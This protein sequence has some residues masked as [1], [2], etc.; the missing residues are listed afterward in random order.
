MVAEV[1]A[2]TLVA[3]CVSESSQTT[4]NEVIGVCRKWLPA[5]MVPGDVVLLDDFPY[6]ASGKCDRKA[7]RA[8]YEQQQVPAPNDGS[9]Q[10]ESESMRQVLDCL[11]TTLGAQLTPKS[12]LAAAGLDSISSIRLASELRKR[13]LAQT[14]AGRVL[15]AETPADI[16]AII[17]GPGNDL[18]TADWQRRAKDA[19][20]ES[21]HQS[22]AQAFPPELRDQVEASFPCTP[23]QIAMLTETAKT[24]RVYCNWIKLAVPR[25]AD[26]E[27]IKDSLSELAARHP[28][29]RSGFI[30][31]LGLQQSYAVVVWKSLT[32]QQVVDVTEFSFP[33]ELKSERDF[34]RPLKFQVR[35]AE[36]GTELLVQIHHALYDQWSMDMLRADLASILQVNDRERPTSFEAVA[37]FYI[38][39]EQSDTQALADFWQD[40]LRDFAASP[41]PLLR[42][43]D[44]VPNLLRT[45][46]QTTSLQSADVKNLSK[47]IG[48]S[49]PAVFQTAMAII[50]G[51]YT[52]VSDVTFG[53]VFSGRTIPVDGIETIFGPCLATLPLRIDSK[54]AKT[55]RELLGAV[56]A[57][58]R[59]IQ[60]NLLTSPT[61]VR[62]AAGIAPGTKLFDSLFVWQESTLTSGTA[63]DVKE[64]DSADELEFDFVLEI[65]PSPTAIQ[66]RAT[67]QERL[68]DAQQVELFIRQIE[69]LVSIML[70]DPDQPV[71][72][73]GNKMNPELL[74][75]ANPEPKSYATLYELAAE[76]G[77]SASRD[78]DATAIIFATK[79]DEKSFE[80]TSIT[81]QD[82]DKRANR[83]A[84]ALIAAGLRPDDLVCICME[85]CID[86]Y[87][88]M[89]ATFKA[90]AG[91]LP[92]IP[93]T[94]EARI[95]SVL[96]Q[97]NIRLCVG[98]AS[99]APE[100]RSLT[101]AKVLDCSTLELANASDQSPQVDQNGARIAY[102][103]F[104]SGSTGEPKGV[105]VTM[106]NLK[107]N[108]AVLAEL[109]K[110]APG[111]RLLQA[112]SQ[113]FD[114]SVFEIFFTFYT[115]MCL[116]SATKDVIFRDFE[117]SIRAF[118][119]THLSLTPTVAALAKPENVPTV[120]FLVTAG[121]A[122]TEKVHRTWADHGLHQGYGPSETT[123]ICSV[124]MNV[125][126]H[127]VLGNIGPPFKNT[128][129]FVLAP[130]CDFQ[131][132]PAGAYGE[133]AFGGEQVFRGYIGRDDL[134][135]T[136]IIDHPSYGRVYRSGDMGR[137]LPDGT[138]L[139]AGRLDDQV[140][141]RGNR[142]ELGE[143]NNILSDHADVSD[144]AT[145]VIG[146]KSSDQM[147]VTFWVPKSSETETSSLSSVADS[148]IELVSDLYARLDDALPAYMIP[149]ILVPMNVLPMTVQGKLDKR[150]LRTTYEGLDTELRNR[151]SRSQEFSAQ[152]GPATPTEETMA[153]AISSLLEIP[154][155][156]ISRNASFF[157][158]GLNSLNA[159]Q[160]ARSFERA[161]GIDVSVS[162]ILRHSTISR[163]ART[164]STT[165]SSGS[166]NDHDDASQALGVDFVEKTKAD[167]LAQD[168]VV[169]AVLPCTPLQDAMLSAS[170]SG[171]AGTYCNTTRIHFRGDMEKMR[172][173]WQRASERHAILRTSF[174]ETPLAAHPFAQ[175]V[176]Q[177]PPPTWVSVGRP[178]SN[179]ITN[180]NHE[181]GHAKSN[182]HM[183]GAQNG[184]SNDAPRLPG[185]TPDRPVQ[186]M[187]N[188]QDIYLQMHHAIY[189]G[190]SVSK[191]FS[192]LQ[193][194]YEGEELPQPVPFEP[195]LAEVMQ[196]NNQKAVDFW[197]QRLHSFTPH[198]VPTADNVTDTKEGSWA[199]SMAISPSDIAAFS[200]RY[201]CTSL[202]IFQAAWA[203]TIACAQDI[204]DLCFGNVVS[205][206]SVPTRDVDRLIAPCFNT[207]PVRVQS[208][209]MRT[210]I[211]LIQ[212]LQKTNVECMS[213]QLTALRRIQALSQDP[214]RHLFDSLLLVQPPQDEDGLWDVEEEDDMSMGVPV[215][216][217]VVPHHHDYELLTH[218]MPERINKSTAIM[219][220]KAFKSSLQTCLRYPSGSVSQLGFAK[221]SELAGLL[222]PTPDSSTKEG[223]SADSDATWSSDE[224]MVRE[225]FA[226]L[227]GIDASQIS[228]E[229]SLYRI[230]LDSLNAV[231]VASQLRKRNLNVDAA[232]IMHYQSPA[233]LAAFIS[234]K[235][236]T[237]QETQAAGIDL[238]T[239]EEQHKH[240]A[241]EKLGIDVTHIEA[242]RPCTSAQSG[243]LSQF[244]QSDGGYYF[245]RSIYKVPDDIHLTH[246][247]TA[248]ATV[249]KKHQVL[250]MGF[251]ELENAANPFAMLVYGP[252]SIPGQVVSEDH[253]TALDD[254]H[255]KL[256][257][258]V[259][260]ELHLPTWR[261]V[262][263]QNGTARHMVVSLHH[264][265]YDAD[266]LHILLLDF[267]KAL[268]NTDI[269]QSQSIDTVLKVQLD[270]MAQQNDNS[271]QFWRESLQ[272]AHLIKF[273]NLT[274][275]II[276]KSQATSTEL[277]SQ[278]HLSTLDEYCRENG[279]TIQ[280]LAQGT[281]AQLLAAYLGEPAVTF[282]T[283]FSGLSSSSAQGVAFPSI[284]TVP[285]YCNTKKSG[286]DVAKDMVT[287]NSSAQ[288]HRFTPLVDIQRFAGTPGQPLFD[289]I[290]VYQKNAKSDDDCFDW[291]VVS[292][293]LGVDYSVS[294]E[295]QAD[296]SGGMS[297]R[298]TYDVAMVP[299][300]HAILMLRQFDMLLLSMI[301]H[302]SKDATHTELM[303]IVP[304]KEPVLPSKVTLLHQFLEQGALD[305]PEKPAFEFVFSL[306]GGAE[307]RKIWSYQELNERGNQV[308]NLI[309]QH[310]VQPGGV[311][312]LCMSKSPEAT[313]AFIGILKAGCAFLAMDPDLPLA[314]RKFIVEDSKS[315]LLFVNAGGIDPEMKDAVRH[316]ELTEDSLINLPSSAP[317]IESVDPS[318]TSY[319]LY[320]SGT[321]GTPKGCELT[322]ENAVQAM[323]AFQRLFAE[324]WSENSRWLQFASYWFDVS[325]LEHFWSWSVGITMVGAP[326]DV[327]LGDLSGF[328]T[329]ANITH[330]DLTPSLARLLKP[331]EVPSLHNHVFITG[332]EALKQEIIDAWGPLN[333]IY[334]GY[335]P[336]EAT[337]GVT[338]NPHIGRDA[339]PSN[340]GPPFDNVGAFVM[341][342]ESET[343]VLRGA[344]GELCVS[345]KLVGKGYLNRPELTEKA[346]PYL[347]RF[348]ERV[349]RT[350]D[351]VRLLADGSISFIG[352]ND[353]QAKLRGQRLEIDEIDAVIKASH[354]GISDVA[355]LVTKSSEGDREMLV[356]FVVDNEARDRELHIAQSKQSVEVVAA[357]D[358]ACRDRLPGYMVPTHIVPLSR[359]PLTVNNKVDAKR[360]VALFTSLTTQ[361]LQQLKGGSATK[362]PLRGKERKVGKVVSK[363]LSIELDDIS[364]TSNV[365]SLGLSS[366]SA[367]TLATSLKRSGFETASVRTIM[368]NPTLD[369]LAQALSGT[370]E[371]GKNERSAIMQSQ[372][373]ISAFAQRYRGLAAQTLSVNVSNIE[374]IAPC[375]PLQE[376]LL[377]DSIKDSERPYFNVFRYQLRGTNHDRVGE[378]ILELY[379][380]LP[381]LRTSFVRTEEGF[382]QVVLRNTDW[383]VQSEDVA[384]DAGIE[385]KLAGLRSE[386][387]GRAKNEV[388]R[389]F[390]A[391]LVHSPTKSIMVLQSH[392][393][394]YDGI[395]WDL[396]MSKLG[397]LCASSSASIDC[398]PSFMEALPYGPLCYRKDAEQFWQRQMKGF[399]YSLLPLVPDE[400]SRETLT[401]S[402]LLRCS[403]GV[404]SLRKKLG[405]SDQAVFQAAFTVAL[406]QY[407]PQTQTYGVV[408]SGR[409]IAFDD[410]DA[411][412][413]PMFNTVPYT[414]NMEP[415]DDWKRHLQRCHEANV[416]LIPYQHTSLRAIR[417]NCRRNPTDPLFDVL[418]VFQRPDERLGPHHDD[419]FFELMPSVTPAEYPLAIEVELGSSGAAQVT[420]AAQPGRATEQSLTEFLDAFDEALQCMIES[421]EGKIS[422]SFTISRS[423]S[424]TTPQQL[425]D[426][427]AEVNGISDFKWTTEAEELR[428]IIAEVAGSDPSAVTE[429]VA[430][431]TLGLDSIDAVKLAA[432]MKKAGMSIPVSKILTAQTIPRMLDAVES[433]TAQ[434]ETPESANKF[435]VLARQLQHL[436]SLVDPRIAKE[437]ERIIPAAPGQEALIAEMIR[438]EFHEYFNSVVLRLRAGVDIARLKDAWQDVVHASPILRTAFVEVSDP[439]VEATFA[440][441]VFKEGPLEFDEV[442]ATSLDGLTDYLN[443]VKADVRQS[444]SVK[445][446]M[447]LAIATVDNAHYLV[448]SLSH[449]QYD[450]HSIGLLHSDIAA[451][452]AGRLER[453]PPYEEVINEALSATDQ[454][455]LTFWRETLAGAKVSRF[456][457]LEGGSDVKT[458]RTERTAALSGK[459]AK[460]FCQKLGVSLQ[461]LAQASWALVL[462]HHLQALDVLFGVVLACRD[463]EEAEQTLFPTMNTVPVRVS[464]HG[465]VSGMLH[466]VQDNINHMRQHQKTPLRNIQAACADLLRS[467]KDKS[468]QGLFD[469]LFIYQNRGDAIEDQ[470]EPLYESVAADANV[471]YPVAVEVE[472][473]EDELVIRAACKSF[474][475]DEPG[476]EL[477]LERFDGVLSFL[478]AELDR[479]AIDLSNDDVVICGLP[480]F[481]LQSN[482]L[483]RQTT[484]EQYGDED[485]DLDSIDDSAVVDAIRSALAQ[486]SRTPIDEIE[487]HATIE[488]M[489]IDSIS[490][491][492]VA[493]LLRKDSIKLSV[494]D[495]LKAQTPRRMAQ[496][497]GDVAQPAGESGVSGKDI[498]ATAIKD[499]DLSI[500]QREYSIPADQIEVVLPATAG[501]MYMVSLWHKTRGELFYP[502]FTYDLR[503]DK[504]MD[505]IR[506]AWQQ[507]V[508]GTAMLRTQ[509]CASGHA[510]IPLLQ[511][512]MKKSGQS[513][514]AE[515]E[516]SIA[517]TQPFA[518]L[519]VGKA[520]DGY[521]LKL[522]IHHALYDAVSLP[523][524]MEDFRC[525]L[526][527]KSLPKPSLAFEDYI[528]LVAREPA[529]KTRQQFWTGYLQNVEHAALGQPRGDAA[530]KVQIFKPSA[531]SESCEELERKARRSGI[532][533][534]ALLFAVYA[535]VYGK[536]AQG[537][538]EGPQDVVLGIYIANRSHLPDLD[539]LSAPTLNLLPLLVRAPT[540]TSIMDSAK[541]ISKDLRSITTAE[542][543]SASLREI[544][545]WTGVTVDTFVNFL[546][547]PDSDDGSDEGTGGSEITIAES[548]D[549]WK[550]E[551][552][553]VHEP[554]K[555]QQQQQQQ[556]EVQFHVP[557]EL[558]GFEVHEAYQH[559]VDVELAI[560]KDGKLS[561]GM[562]C[563]EEM[564]GLD[565]VDV[566][567]EEVVAEL[568]DFVHG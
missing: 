518:R 161:L 139:I 263:Q 482:P 130:E 115:G 541:S 516:R 379:R 517:P 260:S 26:R 467:S 177:K 554:E 245:S 5:F 440:Q 456:R 344:V 383:T 17:D 259:L 501:Q 182:G 162:S 10:S 15:A 91:Y 30:P 75:I 548:N 512:V 183:N 322:H 377:A 271:E 193:Q 1:I 206:R 447:R 441:I 334:N 462:A 506:Q 443:S 366:V 431:F 450:G 451:A 98:D 454:S 272:P 442:Q 159:I 452:Y 326:R 111:D 77:E 488:S 282:G 411:I 84:H 61:A 99:S 386:W 215:V 352:R 340:I 468:R 470:G 172:Q 50:L 351:L 100:L 107:G 219:L 507:L 79:L 277:R 12:S 484:R 503:T 330:I 22:L 23:V 53:S 407:A 265:L 529:V 362:R 3:F 167:F 524:L 27:H 238:I 298:L 289:T 252:D 472:A 392:H 311:V 8:Q 286:L 118:G 430:I 227:A 568:H 324:H 37:D 314:R 434:S 437:V 11:Q 535:K 233:A 545:E 44:V 401:V 510:T 106:D 230:G 521:T 497:V 455:A 528:T 505:A 290:F 414:I 552:H 2:N 531:L 306:E 371:D 513:F 491:I 201:S 231:Q 321:T 18:L 285:V 481:V 555:A 421:A 49:A 315:Q 168:H 320:T 65:E 74:S 103:V 403:H 343:P 175:V 190:I 404:E 69:N 387:Q 236:H 72:D 92:L 222:A 384:D 38:H 492:K 275:T 251:F 389:P 444:F 426:V 466:D 95:K 127:N 368:T 460:A 151:L 114:V 373:T 221:Q 264:A 553:R 209:S 253:E 188:G 67:Y 244:I 511:V 299:V 116:C 349:Y 509:L 211:E 58:N 154:L 153:Q 134:N 173:C 427:S 367:I 350:G 174:V 494:S 522:A 131:V 42:G 335:G 13:G 35:Q 551:V 533:T 149:S 369:R 152:D 266:A 80:S 88:L 393:A 345:G 224:N 480:A 288:R 276:R 241:A 146:D 376:G 446:P 436:S 515:D 331:E 305:H 93:D 249:Q 181:N 395:S 308:A 143:I 226:T 229:T 536:H 408:V 287:Y 341:A 453:R 257:A 303:S 142:V 534:Q 85:K 399:H 16:V 339:K 294:L 348:G 110:V 337:I 62:N 380:Q 566:M 135:S 112:C 449:A 155:T 240:S 254:L 490:A 463:S 319:C 419:E 502:T 150:S 433:S 526:Q 52:G 137:I 258:S 32:E 46:W 560:T 25:Y 283:V 564:L 406:H 86:M 87:V 248:W 113:A 228:K 375:T 476:A 540:R 255:K 357:A 180:G 194:L 338:M 250:R 239:F 198:P 313:F 385:S 390:E 400:P 129:A 469:T 558:A 538:K 325:V 559:A 292:D 355:S 141:I 203:K 514:Y 412:I 164:L 82:L 21:L 438:S 178:I 56:T 297:L 429:H 370:S 523:L 148:G 563:V 262:L 471:E 413:G 347:E 316:V 328:I 274:P 561:M 519:H 448:L 374:S 273:P 158:F 391:I 169:E 157:A 59:R 176:S 97:A 122:V 140:K 423:S 128:S 213:Y 439:E 195:F 81:Y 189:D 309:H 109:Y 327:V 479:D 163:L 473:V 333:T 45:P 243:M 214:S 54:A 96:S 486:V 402:K 457:T 145:I 196:Q 4:K 396:M 567:V 165:D 520:R 398:G 242:V 121:E 179:G 557:Q 232:D 425:H 478:T 29:L 358:Q 34:W 36:A 71:D 204:T 225:V 329:A 556:Q 295:L 318:A 356:S 55:S 474:A 268:R 302:Q 483:S 6:L 394:L 270:G 381:I 19:Y 108:L 68:L 43:V 51:A 184:D 125:P 485:S 197:K 420:A 217:E 40:Y 291:E 171:N 296:G 237:K 499:V 359:L 186:V 364:A 235:Q 66:M 432:R 409:S 336:T 166:E 156:N 301:D 353:S 124:R 39:H 76:I 185:V 293:S 542:N 20:H 300:D 47:S 210:N 208:S 138:L 498:I 445:S 57:Y 405:V 78:P 543:S 123:N 363:L 207:I 332:G 31:T 101:D 428:K 312:A 508:A 60:N 73:L 261:V 537:S 565:E 234:S 415:T 247:Q 504:S 212:D 48:C 346:F 461:A 105:A 147:L 202:S 317:Q 120:R 83:M 269:G 487:P 342:P 94:P 24:P 388:T 104:T 539:H 216:I 527:G 304:P 525:L 562:F 530:R 278:T 246:I 102:A 532:S 160:L 136:K 354:K 279:V 372:L 397:E 307:S 361:G 489:G 550:Q 495:L 132:L 200:E 549:E 63:E 546:K 323:L 378:A 199:M 133:F 126:A 205:G 187:T 192:E 281:W 458:Y 416:E 89:L 220:A 191:L 33:F 310:G 28:L 170:R 477:L 493:S 223:A 7:L 459:D 70:Q 544:C 422:D 382:A 496:L 267:A 417:K 475:L 218:F 365:F 547:L 424:T 90:G 119:V 117:Q 464:L 360:L 64:V 256:S 144:C 500:L 280:A 465:S 418:F 41:M 9:T 14:D 410:A 284:S 435:S